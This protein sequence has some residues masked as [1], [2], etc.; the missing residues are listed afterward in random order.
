MRSFKDETGERELD[1]HKV[2]KWAAGK[3]WPLPEP[4]NPLDLLAKQFADAA[5]V[6]IRHDKITGRPYRVN[7]SIVATQG[8]TQLHLWI[9]IDE[10]KRGPMLKSLVTRREQM[11]GDG[12]QLTLDQ[13]HWNAIHPDEEPIQLPMDFSLDI[14]WRKNAPDDEGKAA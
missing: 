4:Q 6:E 8:G 13:D 5:R 1:M 3:G 12:Y 14:E 7:H 2:A 10:A 11:I 9:D